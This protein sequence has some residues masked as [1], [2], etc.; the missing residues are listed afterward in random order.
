MK[1]KLIATAIASLACATTSTAV[2]ADSAGE[3]GYWDAAKQGTQ[4]ASVSQPAT[5]PQ[6]FRAVSSSSTSA[7]GESSDGQQESHGRDGGT[8]APAVGLGNLPTTIVQN[9]SLPT[10]PAPAPV[11]TNWVGYA[12][13]NNFADVDDKVKIVVGPDWKPGTMPSIVTVTAGGYTVTESVQLS[14]GPARGGGAGATLWTIGSNSDAMTAA[15]AQGGY[16]A[17]YANTSASQATFSGAIYSCATGSCQM[18]GYAVGGAATSLADLQ[19]LVAGAAPTATYS[20]GG[21]NMTVDFRQGS[22]NGTLA[23]WP[24]TA[25][26]A[27]KV[28][29]ANFR[30]TSFT[31]PSIPSL[32]SAA[33]YVKGTF[34]GQGAAAAGGVWA[35]KSNSGTRVGTFMASKQVGGPSAPN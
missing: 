28:S 7:S 15:N 30:S 2:R 19:A 31:A 4:V 23:I 16:F 29:G 34:Y 14:G 21:L 9:I 20:G 10:A 12:T 6:A 5:T 35:V 27:G 24:S 26:L 11:S 32:D 13:T 8:Q 18:T 3:W 22:W 33:S 17:G 25:T 1:Q